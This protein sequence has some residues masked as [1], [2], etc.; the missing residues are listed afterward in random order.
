M[1][2][3][4]LVE[5]VVTEFVVHNLVGREISHR[6]TQ[7]HT[8]FLYSEEEGGLGELGGVETVFA[9]T[10]GADGEDDADRGILLPQERDGLLQVVGTG[11]DGE[12]FFGK[13]G[14]GTLLTVVDNLAC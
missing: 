14:L 9:V 7:I 12:F 3:V 10:D 5:T 11:L 13:E 4:G 6:F 8:D 2:H 1:E